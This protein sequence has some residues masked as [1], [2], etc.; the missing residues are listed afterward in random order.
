MPKNLPGHYIKLSKPSA[1]LM[2]MSGSYSLRLVSRY[3]NLTA[4]QTRVVIKLV[5]G[6]NIHVANP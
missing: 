1:D 3:Q 2:T 5:L 6:A 4:D